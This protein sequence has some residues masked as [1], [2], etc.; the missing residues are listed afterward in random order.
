MVESLVLIEGENVSA[1]TEEALRSLSLAN[2]KQIVIANV[3][4]FGVILHINASDTDNEEYNSYLNKAL[5]EFA[6]VPGVTRIIPLALR[7][8]RAN[9]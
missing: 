2:A 7:S 1:E 3:Y 5:S 6:K 4:G 8:T 9:G